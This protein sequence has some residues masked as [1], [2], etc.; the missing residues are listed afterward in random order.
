[1]GAHFLLN[2]P[3]I[4]TGPTD[5]RQEYYNQPWLKQ[6]TGAGKDLGGAPLIGTKLS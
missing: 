1:M 5:R 4:Y 6:I 2:Q 3:N